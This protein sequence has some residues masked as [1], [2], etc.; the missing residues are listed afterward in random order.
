MNKKIAFIVD[1]LDF[2]GIERVALDYLRILTDNNYDVDVYNTNH[3]A[4]KLVSSLPD[5]VKYKRIRIPLS[6]CPDR[7]GLLAK[8]NRLGIFLFPIA[9]TLSIL[10]LFFFKWF[11]RLFITRKKYPICISFA[12]HYRDLTV[13]SYNIVKSKKKIA[14]AHG[15][16]IEYLV[17]NPGN[18]YMLKKIHNMVSLSGV[19]DEFIKS[20]NKFINLNINKIYNP[21]FILNSETKDEIVSEYGDYILN[22]ARFEKQK[23]H[24]TIIKAIKILKDNSFNN[25][26]V[27]L[28]DGALFE[29]IKDFAKENGVFEQCVFLGA[30]SDVAKY[31][32]NCKMFVH[33]S[34]AEGLP[35][36]I[37]EA[38]QFDKPVVATASPE[39][40][41][42]ILQNGKYG[43]MSPVGDEV[44][45]AN[46]MMM[47]LK[48][49]NKYDYYSKQSSIRKKDFTPEVA[50]EKVLSFIENL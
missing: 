35:T 46:N 41:Q 31:Y 12:G 22:V 39:G 50:K 1:G 21:T 18:A 4:E 38:M 24:K 32:K 36:V 8:K 48:D 7:Y 27:F 20:S 42:E 10:L 33:S 2:G 30:K 34:P 40:V 15:S 5:G 13:N 29:E 44:E 25:K 19:G 47:I 49:K 17:L 26:F 14:W 23:D 6:L 45:L 43:L 11:Y 3:K 16:A 28:G 9:Y 37:I